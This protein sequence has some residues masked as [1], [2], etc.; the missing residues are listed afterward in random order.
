MRTFSSSM[1]SCPSGVE[2]VVIPFTHRSGYKAFDERHT[3]RLKHLMVTFV[4][5]GRWMLAI[6]K[7]RGRVNQVNLE[8]RQ[9]TPSWRE[10][11]PEMVA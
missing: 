9:L 5:R 1:A 2:P 11:P 4:V 6:S 3:R 8:G 10:K 7:G